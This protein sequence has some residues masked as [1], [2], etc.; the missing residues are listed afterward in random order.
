MLVRYCSPCQSA[1]GRYFAGEFS[2]MLNLI[3][4]ELFISQIYATAPFRRALP[5]VR[6]VAISWIP[7]RQA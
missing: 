7:G 6:I 3:V 2:T 5:A 4:S 1:R